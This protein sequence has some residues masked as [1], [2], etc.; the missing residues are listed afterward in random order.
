VFIGESVTWAVA[1]GSFV[2]R[3][4]CHARLPLIAGLDAARPAVH[5]WQFG[6]D[7]LRE[8]GVVEAGPGYPPEVW[9]RNQ[10]V[11]ALAWHPHE[12]DLVVSGAAGLQRW[13]PDGTRVVAAAPP[14]A[15]YRAVAFSPDGE[16]LWASPASSLDES[17]AWERSDALDLRTGAVRVGPRWDTGVVEHPGGGLLVTLSSDQGATDVLFARP[18]GNDP[19]I[20]RMFRHAIVLDVDGY[21]T[22]VMSDDGRYLAFRGNAYV[23]S[24]D[25][26]EFPSLRRVLHTTLGEPYPGYPYP[27]EWIA[28]QE[29]WSRHNI[30]FA[31]RSATLLIGT[32]EGEILALDVDSVEVSAHEIVAAA[33]VSALAV[34]STGQVVVADRTGR[35]AVMDAPANADR[36]GRPAARHGSPSSSPGPARYPTA[37]TWRTPWCVTTDSACGT[38]MTWRR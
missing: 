26:F 27:P 33:P 19:A 17:E 6:P 22:P 20:P 13:S 9:E 2:E 37:P 28:E 1:G 12:P 21:E 8:H 29:R 16:T 34:A 25:V 15:G 4:V 36:D 14:N 18:D 24:L 23:E 3:L 32:A 11:P 35:V 31:P 38:P 7:G 30:A 10:S 5:I